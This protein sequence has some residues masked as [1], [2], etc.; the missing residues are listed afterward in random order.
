M[1]ISIQE[2]M[3]YSQDEKDKEI[4]RCLPNVLNLNENIAKLK[5]S[6]DHALH[7]LDILEQNHAAQKKLE[8]IDDFLGITRNPQFISQHDSLD[9]LHRSSTMNSSRSREGL[10]LSGVSSSPQPLPDVSG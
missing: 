7:K 4:M 5:S 10:F 9:N 3:K 6:I 8:K 2:F 1:M